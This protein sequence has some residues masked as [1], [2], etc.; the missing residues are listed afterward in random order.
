M[1]RKQQKA[2][3]K[4]ALQDGEPLALVVATGYVREATVALAMCE[5][6][7][8]NRVRQDHQNLCTAEAMLE[9]ALDI[10]RANKERLAVLL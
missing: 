8:A 5:H 7:R 9:G 6:L 2:T 10:V 1:V 3:P 4:P